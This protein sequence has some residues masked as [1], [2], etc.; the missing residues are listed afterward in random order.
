MMSNFRWYAIKHV[1]NFAAGKIKRPFF[2]RLRKVRARNIFHDSNI[3]AQLNRGFGERRL[4][5]RAL[6][7]VIAFPD[8]PK[9]GTNYDLALKDEAKSGTAQPE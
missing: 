3:K 6:S 2:N 7:F 1:L 9:L 8:D 5:P 4:K